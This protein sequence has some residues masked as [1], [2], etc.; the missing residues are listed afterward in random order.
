MAGL[1]GLFQ[2]QPDQLQSLLGQYYSPQQSRMSWLGGTLQ[3]IGA[4]IASGRPGAWATMGTYGGGD[5]L[6]AY[7]QRAL[8]MYGVK[9]RADDTAYQHN[10]DSIGDKR[11]QQEWGYRQAQD[12]RT[13]ARADAELQLQMDAAQNP[14]L[15][16]SIE[17]YNFAKQ[18]GFPGTYQD[19]EIAKA[20]AG[21]QTVNVNGG[22]SDKQIFDATQAQSD[23]AKAAQRGLSSISAAQTALPGAITGAGAD[24]R[25]NFQKIGAMMGV[26]DP[27]SIVDTETFR[28]AIAPQVAAMLKS[29]V[30]RTQISN[31]D[32]EFAE[33]AAGGSIT[34]DKGSIQRLLNIMQAANSETIRSF[35]SNL[36]S[37]YPEGQGFDRE[38]ALFGVP[39]VAKRYAYPIGPAQ[40][41]GPQG[42]APDDP[43]GLFQNPQQ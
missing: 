19:W 16:A 8:A 27:S 20:K 25:L 6:D 29:T 13:N 37:V 17:E 5:A 40:G 15:P 24:A 18:Q 32:R 43:L 10:R 41:N 11:W 7:R 28:A 33:K 34:L 30:G 42:M 12:R 31:A 23:A 2:Q 4:G 22:G 1:L 21:A 14:H 35:N 26:A 39:Q 9:Q 38:R 36:D 3:G